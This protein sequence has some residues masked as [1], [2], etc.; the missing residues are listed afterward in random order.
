M[1]EDDQSSRGNKWPK[2]K[3]FGK[4]VNFNQL[5]KLKSNLLN[6]APLETLEAP[7]TWG[8]DP[9]VTLFK[10]Y[11][12]YNLTRELFPFVFKKTTIFFRNAEDEKR[13]LSESGNFSIL[14]GAPLA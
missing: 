5:I 8:K 9:R 4:Q 7:K 13:R 12:S 14:G 2:S 3:Q 6:S 10:T 1:H 11:I